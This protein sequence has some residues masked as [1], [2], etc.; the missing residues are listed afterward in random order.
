MSAIRKHKPAPV[1]VVGAGPDEPGL[2]TLRGAELLAAADV[3]A[4]Q[5]HRMSALLAHVRP[6]AEIID[7]SEGIMTD[8]ELV[9]LLVRHA[10]DGRRVVRLYDG[11]PFLGAGGADLV[12]ACNRGSVPVEVVPGV[13]TATAVPTYAGIPLTDAK[14]RQVLIVDPGPDTDAVDWSTAAVAPV[15]VVLNA[16]SAMGKAAAA[17]VEHGRSGD[18]PV[19]VTSSGARTTQRTLVSTLDRVESDIV[20][21]KFEEPAIAVVGAVVNQRERLSWYETRPLFGWKVLVPRTKDQ[22][23][24]LSEQL[25]DYGAVPVEVP[26]IAVEPPRSPAPMDRG[27]KGLFAGRYQWAVFTSTN[28]VKAVVEKF[29][30]WGLDARAFAGVKIAAVGEQTAAALIAFGIRPDL[31]PSGEHSS[32]GLLADFPPYD[33]VL[34]PI[35]RVFLPRAD[36]A[37]ETLVTGLTERGWEVDDITAYRTVRAA[38]PAAETRDAIK[39]GG[40]DAVLFTS[41]STVRNLVGIA[42]KPHPSTVIAVIGPQT[43]K[44]ADEL[45]LR[46]DVQAPSASTAALAEALADWAVAQREA[47]EAA[48]VKATRRAGATG[49]KRAR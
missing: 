8:A 32:E 35:E 11:D 18:T 22:A 28:A 34:D 4:A 21:S 23:G 1:A 25:R 19:S 42:G 45:G 47:S 41:S 31:V 20:A 33:D 7:T 2:L 39:S 36:I 17:L 24:T 26:T 13:P 43:A 5:S 14:H 12:L 40:F 6:D 49:R 37:T 15:V 46:V 9:K 3:V 48:P 10:R 16:T 27:I 44:T 38:P 29:L 30:D